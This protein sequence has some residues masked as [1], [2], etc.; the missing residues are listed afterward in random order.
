MQA[1]RLGALYK[2]LTDDQRKHAAKFW[3]TVSSQLALE[4]YIRVR[5]APKE[6]DPVV[7]MEAVQY[8]EDHRTEVEMLH[9]DPVKIVDL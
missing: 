1:L 4:I 7:F 5:S 9:S 2:N 6:D 8:C 3:S